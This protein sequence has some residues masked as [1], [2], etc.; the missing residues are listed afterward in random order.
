MRFNLIGSVHSSSIALATLLDIHRPLYSRRAGG[1]KLIAHA[2]LSIW[3]RMPLS[4]CTCLYKPDCPAP[5]KGNGDDLASSWLAHSRFFSLQ[6]R[7]AFSLCPARD[8]VGFPHD[9]STPFASAMPFVRSSTRANVGPEWS[10]M[11]AARLAAGMVRVSS[12][13]PQTQLLGVCISAS[14]SA[15]RWAGTLRPAS[16]AR[17]GTRQRQL[18][19]PCSAGN[20]ICH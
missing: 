15:S 16:A 7:A 18:I 10:A 2:S 17:K 14:R 12:H 13:L 11:M 20:S 6:F 1:Q 5:G 3:C 8:L 19:A 9:R 4:R